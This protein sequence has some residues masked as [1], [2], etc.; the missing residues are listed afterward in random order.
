MDQRCARATDKFLVDET[1]IALCPT[2][3]QAAAIFDDLT[4]RRI[5][6]H[7][8]VDRL[9]PSRVVC[10][11]GITSIQCTSSADDERLLLKQ[12]RSCVVAYRRC[13]HSILRY[14]IFIRHTTFDT[15]EQRNRMMYHKLK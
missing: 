2:A 13:M 1:K 11:G 10:E 7:Q 3:A 5:A 4:R 14:E 9:S 15:E 8:R 12:Q 6:W